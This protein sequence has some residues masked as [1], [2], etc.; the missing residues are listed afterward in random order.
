MPSLQLWEGGVWMWDREDR[1]QGFS[2]DRRRR[3]TFLS[4]TNQAP[5]V[6]G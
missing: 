6:C 5:V 3:K 1:S 2:K 4:L